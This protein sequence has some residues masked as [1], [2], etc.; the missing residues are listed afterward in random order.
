MSQH[1]K[2]VLMLLSL[3]MIGSLGSVWAKMVL[4]LLPMFTF[5]WLMVASGM[6]VLL[7][8]TFVIRRKTI[9]FA[10]LKRHGLKLLLIGLAYFFIYRLAFV[11]ALSKLPVTT[12]AYVINFTGLVTMVLSVI[13]LKE[14]P[15]RSQWAG[16]ILA[17]SGVFVYFNELP[18]LTE[19]LALSVLSFGVLCLA[20]TNIWIRQ[21]SAQEDSGLSSTM[22]A[23]TTIVLGGLPLVLYGLATD[24]PLV[25]ISAFQWFVI[26]LNASVVLS[27]GLII[28]SY[29]LRTIR[30]YEASVLAS[31]GVIYVALFSV[32]ILGDQIEWFEWCGI[33][34]ML[35]GLILMQY[36]PKAKIEKEV[37]N[38]VV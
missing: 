29:A 25:P 7:L 26:V 36:K 38:E 18:D 17:L 21:L 28:W 6:V 35:L 3:V 2:V 1:L 24:L 8:Y 16:G 37:V 32:P 15:S 10:I 33:G 20:L 31:S 5:L 13:M 27:F 34:I 9:P 22:L 4:D 14:H 11:F 30:S 23:T 12:H 19:I